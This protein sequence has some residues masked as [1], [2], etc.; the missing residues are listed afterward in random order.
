MIDTWKYSYS[1]YRNAV[2]R[3]SLLACVLII[4]LS[5]NALTEDTQTISPIE[6]PLEFACDNDNPA[7]VLIIEVTY[8]SSYHKKEYKF[9]LKHR[10]PL[11]ISEDGSPTPLGPICSGS[12]FGENGDGIDL[13]YSYGATVDIDHIRAD[14]AQ[15]HLSYYWKTAKG[16][17]RFDRKL[18]V[19]LF[20]PREYSFRNGI[21]IKSYPR[22]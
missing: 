3:P 22:K 4:L 18:S 10:T 6:G 20:H 15:I 1:L 14:S 5:I 11:Q 19:P 16:K 13:S 7:M 8:P 12:V 9:P 2:L 17:G 21:K